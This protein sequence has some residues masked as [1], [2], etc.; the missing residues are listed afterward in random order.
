MHYVE[1]VL[2]WLGFYQSGIIAFGVFVAA[3]ASIVGAYVTTGASHRSKVS[4]LREK[5]IDE[6]RECLVAITESRMITLKLEKSQITEEEFIGEIKRLKMLSTKL[7]LLLNNGETPH[8]VL[9]EKVDEYLNMTSSEDA[10]EAEKK[11]ID[12]ARSIFRVEWKRIVKA[13]L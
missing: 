7:K 4:E 9:I 1:E 8:A 11:I 2:N 12:L 3:A 10:L 13:D 5:W 6:V